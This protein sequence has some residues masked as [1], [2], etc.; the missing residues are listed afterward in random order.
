MDK[1]RKRETHAPSKPE[2]MDADE[3]AEYK[4]TAEYQHDV[5]EPDIE[6]P[7]E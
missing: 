3:W 4:R 7:D 1:R 6:E 2:H 5:K